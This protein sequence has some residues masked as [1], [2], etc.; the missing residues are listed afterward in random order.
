MIA[1]KERP[2]MQLRLNDA[3]GLVSA[4]AI[5]SLTQ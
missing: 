2:P 1:R 4:L 3:V 5:S